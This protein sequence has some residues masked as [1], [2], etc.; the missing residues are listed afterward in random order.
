MSASDV[1][2][3]LAIA[4]ARRLRAARLALGFDTL[5]KFSEAMGIP[6]ARLNAWELGKALAPPAFI[7]AMQQKF[8]G[9]PDHNFIYTGDMGN[10]THGFA[11]K[12]LQALD[13]L[14]EEIK[15]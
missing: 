11:I 2:H 14:T 4:A 3:P 7:I 10:L 13:S 6:E 15:K 9:M 8:N 1:P 5:R 12:I